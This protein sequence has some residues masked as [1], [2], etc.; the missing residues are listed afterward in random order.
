MRLVWAF[1]TFAAFSGP[2]N[3]ENLSGND[4]LSIC[5]DQSQA[6]QGFCIGYVNGLI[7]GLKLGASVPMMMLNQEGEDIPTSEMDALSSQ[8]LGFCLPPE[9]ELRQFVEIIVAYLKDTPKDRHG[10]A[11]LLGQ[12]A[13]AEAYPCA[14]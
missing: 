14:Q 7:E 8:F 10:S 3:A 13:L 12:I 1:L 9:A 4:L 6:A 5:S 11:R 2:G